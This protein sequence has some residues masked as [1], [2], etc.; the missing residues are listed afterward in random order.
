MLVPLLVLVVAGAL[1]AANLAAM[2]SA[3]LTVA[4]GAAGAWA[5]WRCWG[6]LA[7]WRQALGRGWAIGAWE[8]LLHA[9][10]ARRW[11][12][13]AIPLREEWAAMPSWIEQASD[14]E[15]L[16]VALRILSGADHESWQRRQRVEVFAS[17]RPEM[18]ELAAG[19][20][21]AEGFL[22]EVDAGTTPGVFGASWARG[23]VVPGDQAEEA[24]AF[25][26]EAMRG[27]PDEEPDGG[28]P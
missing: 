11:H 25:L 4:S 7:L 22:V 2:H 14:F 15:N 24:R 5:A 17:R 18:V 8:W 1:F 19:L 27:E 20:L 6:S 23:V 13:K 3:V 12:R 10:D 28:E 16:E 9:E 21:R 26:A